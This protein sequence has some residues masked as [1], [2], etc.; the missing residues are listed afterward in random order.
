MD[1][2]PSRCYQY[3]E[4][5]GIL[6]RLEARYPDLVKLQSIGET[7]EGRDLWGLADG[8]ELDQIGVASF[9]AAEN[10]GQLLILIT[11]GRIVVHSGPPRIRRQSRQ[12]FANQV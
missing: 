2:D 6:R 5:T 12:C 3:E 7:P 1:Y 4:L 9:Q 8:L 10:A 11:S